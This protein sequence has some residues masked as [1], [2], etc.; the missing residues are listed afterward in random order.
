MEHGN[1]SYTNYQNMVAQVNTSMV[2]M[3]KICGRMELDE[4][5]KSL[6]K[7]REKL[8]EHKFAVG[9]MGEF[10]RGKSTVINSMLEKEIMPAD[11]LPCSATMN[12]VTY[13]MQ[14][15]VE[16]LMKDNSIK[17]ISIDDLAGYVTK[18]TGE[19]EA[20]ASQVE[21]A[22]VYY[23]CRFCQNGV[24]IVDTPG[25]NDDERMNRVTEEVIPKLDAV[26]MVITP[27]NPFSMSEA[28]FVRSK[29]MASDLG[30]LIFLVNKID[31][32]RR[33]ADRERVVQGIRE[34]IQRSV[35]DKMAELYGKDSEKY[36]D[37]EFKMGNIRIYPFSALDALDGKMTGDQKLIEE[38][39]T[40]PF[41][42]A[43]T[44]MLTEER[45]ALE[46]GTPLNLIQRT[47]LEV[48]KAAETRK[49]ALELDAEEFEKHQKE[50]L[51]K[52]GEMRK[53][54]QEEKRRLSSSA[55]NAKN[56]LIPQVSQ[57]YSELEAKL[58]AKLENT[59]I[60]VTTLSSDGGKK[61]AAEKLQKAVSDEMRSSMSLLSE[62]IELQLQDIVGKEAVRLGEFTQ[63]ISTQMDAFRNSI[64]ENRK[65]LDKTNLIGTGVDVL[66]D[67]MGIYGIGGIVAGYREAGVK[68]ALA[69]GGVGL[70]ATLR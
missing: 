33:A 5:K 47:S 13:D 4:N 11:I 43:L 2:Q 39:G 64:T 34:K 36:K 61:A 27:D 44:K 40:L 57:F 58:A 53:K 60:D 10:K 30:R 49:K 25:L 45:G 28:E 18:L 48:I 37:S 63:E 38:S 3:E 16:L 26:I 19:N 59:P 29:L 20:R 9:I 31:T 1:A 42:E 50:A 70:V 7:S 62:K 67:F 14:P 69:G 8:A 51:A 56:K 6:E 23:P 54:K 46:L 66:T 52:I 15:H 68:G 32:I 65:G 41:E 22:V 55:T 35:L 12:R 24:D 21:E 17:N